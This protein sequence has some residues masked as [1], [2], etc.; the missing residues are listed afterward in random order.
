MKFVCKYKSII[1]GDVVKVGQVV[2]LTDAEAE[3]GVVKAHFVPV[4]GSAGADSASAVHAPAPVVVAGLTREQAIMKLAE[5]GQRVSSRISDERLR[6]RFEE[7]FAAE[8]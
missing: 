4:D 6:Q 7:A 8:Q 3:M 2:N 5:A 1:R